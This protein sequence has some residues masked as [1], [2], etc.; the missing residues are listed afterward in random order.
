MR[1]GY[2]LAVLEGGKYRKVTQDMDNDF[3]RR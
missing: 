2:G 3:P 1:P